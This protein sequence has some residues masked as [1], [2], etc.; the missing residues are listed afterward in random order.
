MNNKKIFLKAG[1][2]ILL[3]VSARAQTFTNLTSS[4]NFTP[5]KLVVFRL[6]EIA[7]TNFNIAN[8]RQQPAFIDEY[9]PAITNQGAPLL[10]VALPTND[11]VNSL[12]VNAHAGSEGQ[13]FTRSADRQ[14]LTMTGYTSPINIAEGTPSSATNA[15]GT[16]VF[17]R[18]FGLLDNSG[19]FAVIYSSQFWYGI[20]PGITQ[21]NPRG[22]ATDGTNSYWGGGTIAG[23]Q[24]GGFEETGTLFYNSV[25]EGDPQVVQATV[26]STYYDKIVNNVLYFVAHNEAGGATVNGIFNFVDTPDNGGAPV[27]LP[28]LPGGVDHIVVTNLFLNFG[29]TYTNVLAF[30][31]NQA[32]TLVYTADTTYG[33]VKYTNN[34]AG[35]WSSTYYFS[36]TNLGTT[37]QS[38]KS[39][40][41][42]GIAVDFSGANPVIYATTMEEGDGANTCS[43]RLISI[44]DTGNPGTNLVAQTLVQAG[45]INEVL[46]GV[47]FAPDLR[48]AITSEPANVATTNHGT[49][50]FNIQDQCVTG[51]SYQ[52]LQNGAVL[53][54]QTSS[55]LA[56]NN[57]STNFNGFTYACV[58]SNQ[59]GAVTSSPALLTVTF[60]AE[61]PSLTNGV[62][63][64]TN[65]VGDTAL[66]SVSP[67]GD[68]PFTYQWYFGTTKLM[69][70]GIKYSGSTSASLY[71]TNVQTSDSGNYYLTISNVAGGISN[72]VAVLT[73]VY[74]EPAIGPG[75]EPVSLVMLAGQTNSLTVS[76]ITGTQPLN[77]QW[78]Q[79][80]TSPSTQLYNVNEFSGTTTNI[81]TISGVAISDA[82]N[83]FCVVSNN[84][85]G[86]VSTVASVTVITPPAL[87]YVPYSNQVYTQ[88]FDT[89][90]YQPGT[91]INTDSGGGF[92]TINGVVYSPANP[93]DFAFPLFTNISGG[94][95]GGL[96]L[97]NTMPGWYGECDIVQQGA[98]I[99]AANGSTTTGGIYS[100]GA[101]NNSNRALGLIATSSSLGTHFG[102][103]LINT[104][105]GNLNYISLQYLGEYWKSGTHAKTMLNSYYIGPAGNASTLT[106]N[107][108]V[109][110]QNNT[111]SNLSIS[112]PTGLMGA[113]NGYAAT[114]QTNCQV[115]YVPLSSAWTPGSALWLIWSIN[116]ATGSG[117]GYGIDNFAFYAS[118]STLPGAITPPIFSGLTFTQGNGSQLNFTTAPGASSYLN[119]YSSTNLATPFRQW[120]NLGNPTETSFGTYQFNDSQATNSG[121]TVLSCCLHPAGTKLTAD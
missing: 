45:G 61:A 69:D 46:R 101:T 49:A 118:A 70:D 14:F 56:L 82:T 90:P 84:G 103:K 83:Y 51:V 94:N 39:Q 119:V 28:W 78:Y 34:G 54:G 33:I 91:N 6:G 53:G 117:Q 67:G 24:S 77:Y 111:L 43:N 75:G 121:A 2:A 63:N 47:A 20:Q 8:V 26:N 97:S 15:D 37:K 41:C 86:A 64:V 71:I 10:S 74:L 59:Y 48:P 120:Q 52:W 95:S 72:E 116:D 112:F 18:G 79:G 107:E 50:N 27:P 109:N 105:G 88:N 110:S 35:T 66:L 57:L 113:M 114:N 4:N 65:F 32:G 36:S 11:P 93:Y 22:I 38:K 99:G 40:G 5:G 9:D 106:S 17:N 16:G 55:A 85:G 23:S 13:G 42:F 12:F 102:L 115:M 108:V 44:V 104:T 96:A 7:D 19:N 92:Q 76:E 1:L 62:A 80:N 73:V 21:N 31:M 98:Q 81:L 3:A 60:V 30:D 25:E 68:A 87:S 58:V 100:F 89:V 29:N